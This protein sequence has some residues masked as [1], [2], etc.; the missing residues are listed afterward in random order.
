[1]KGIIEFCIAR[2]NFLRQ[3][4]KRVRNRLK[5]IDCKSIDPVTV[6]IQIQTERIQP[7]QSVPLFTL[8][9][10]VVYT[11][12]FPVAGPA[13]TQC[14]IWLKRYGILNFVLFQFTD[15]L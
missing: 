6:A 8:T 9:V 5:I 2:I 3:C 11:V 14:L 7:E 15:S 10:G 4:T 13:L 1:M 12:T